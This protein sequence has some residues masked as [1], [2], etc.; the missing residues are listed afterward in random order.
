VFEVIA[1]GVVPARIAFSTIENR[2][3]T[4]EAWRADP[5]RTVEPSVPGR[6][7]IS[8]RHD[9]AILAGVRAGKSDKAIAVEL[10]MGK[11]SWRVRDRR[12]RLQHEFGV[13]DRRDLV[14]LLHRPTEGASP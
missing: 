8:R 2:R 11:A 9:A 13:N 5:V 4:V 1:G 3:T 10:G 14:A 7:G 6:P 12:Q